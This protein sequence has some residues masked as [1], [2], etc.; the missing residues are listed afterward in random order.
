[1]LKEW[2]VSDLKECEYNPRKIDPETLDKL[3]KSIVDYGLVD[4]PIINT[5]SCEDCGER[6]GIIIGGNQRLKAIRELNYDKVNVVEINLHV[7]AEKDLNVRLN[8]VGGDWDLFLL[9][10]LKESLSLD[11]LDF[12]ENLALSPDVLA[13]LDRLENDDI[14]LSD[15][16]F[17]T[18]FDG[19]VEFRIYLPSEFRDMQDDV[20]SDLEALKGTYAP[21]IL[22]RTG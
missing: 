1:M 7:E 6:N 18:K 4:F 8:A 9:Q 19:A 12:S 5:H 17:N 14:D 2:K 3:K 11:A 20:W 21:L 15:H 13:S 10:D 16:D 22:K